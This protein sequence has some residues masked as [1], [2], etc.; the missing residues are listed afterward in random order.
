MSSQ[1]LR[2]VDQVPGQCEPMAKYIGKFKSAF[3]NILCKCVDFAD[4]IYINDPKA[5]IETEKKER[6][7]HLLVL[8]PL[9]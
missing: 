6:E 3:L 5:L 1:E 7:N 9:L 8:K 2:S 4:K